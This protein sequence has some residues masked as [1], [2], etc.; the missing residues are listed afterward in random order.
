M[1]G[2][3]RYLAT[4][5]ACGLTDQRWRKARVMAL[6]LEE[7]TWLPTAANAVWPK[8]GVPSVLTVVMDERK[9]R[10]A[11]STDCSTKSLMITVL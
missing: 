11:S 9:H 2:L 5:S 8:G 7:G 4:I 10:M 3:G 6:V 1:T